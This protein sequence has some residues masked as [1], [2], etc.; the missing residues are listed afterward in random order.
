MIII[1]LKNLK[2]KIAKRK[3]RIIKKEVRRLEKK[4]IREFRH[5]INEYRT[6]CRIRIETKYY[7]YYDEIYEKLLEKLKAS[8][9]YKDLKF[10]T[11]QDMT[12][13]DYLLIEL[14]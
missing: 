8:D 5:A 6:Y 13:T 14:K 11:K 7:Y 12:G 2:E 10:E 3:D 9:K 4:A 1:S